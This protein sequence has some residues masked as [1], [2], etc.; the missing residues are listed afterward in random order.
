MLMWTW[1][2]IV[3]IEIQSQAVRPIMATG[4][5]IGVQ[6]R[7]QLELEALAQAPRARVI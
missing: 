2:V 7:H 6:H 4:H 3:S 1:L 5:A